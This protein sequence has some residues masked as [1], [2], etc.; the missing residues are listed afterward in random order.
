M[1]ALTDPVPP[2]TYA[3]TIGTYA[4]TGR[5]RSRIDVLRLARE[6]LVLVERADSRA[7]GE[8][9]ESLSRRRIPIGTVRVGRAVLTVSRLD[10]AMPARR[11]VSRLALR[12]GVT[13]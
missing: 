11:P 9:V 3:A 12:S 1:S 10:D 8:A 7:I 6:A 2:G 13:R 5:C 4:R